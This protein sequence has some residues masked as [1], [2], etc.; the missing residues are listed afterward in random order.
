MK[1]YLEEVNGSPDEEKKTSS[2]EAVPVSGITLSE[3]RRWK[4]NKERGRGWRGCLGH[5]GLLC[6]GSV[7]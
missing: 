3:F 4:G 6:R 1:K 2:R 5:Q 7:K